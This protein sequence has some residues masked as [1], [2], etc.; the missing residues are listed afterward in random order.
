MTGSDLF[1]WGVVKDVGMAVPIFT[2][3]P[4]RGVAVA[5]GNLEVYTGGYNCEYVI[6]QNPTNRDL[7]SDPDFHK[8]L[9]R[10]IKELYEGYNNENQTNPI[11]HCRNN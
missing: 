11:G 8:Y 2:Q 7:D 4:F 3:D 9:E 5:L 1:Q 10:V 6:V